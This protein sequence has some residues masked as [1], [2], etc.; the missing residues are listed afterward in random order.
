MSEAHKAFKANVEGQAHKA[1][2]ANLEGQ[3]E[4]GKR[5][6]RGQPDLQ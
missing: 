2:K 5:D 6:H 1:L 3:G 4:T